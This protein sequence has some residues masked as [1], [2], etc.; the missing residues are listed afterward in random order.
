MAATIY[1]RVTEE[2]MKRLAAGVI[3]WQKPWNP[4]HGQPKNLHTGRPY[5]GMNVWLLGGHDYP[6]SYWITYKQAQERGGN[7]RRGE[8]GR[9]VVF[10]QFDR[11]S[12]EGDGTRTDRRPAPILRYYTVF[13]TAQCDGLEV[14]A[15]QPFTPIGTAAGIAAGMPNPPTLR[16]GGGRACYAPGPDLVQMPEP[17]S[18][19]R[20]ARY[21]G[22]LF[23]ELAHATGHDS[24]LKRPGIQNIQPFGTPDYSREELVAE[25]AAAYL[26]AAAG[27]ENETLDN[28][29]AYLKGWTDALGSDP[30]LI[31]VAAGQ[32]QK[33][34]DYILDTKPADDAG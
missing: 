21:Y 29:A 18:F 11:E 25:M 9:L 6:A 14:P 24:R 20:P 5:R 1:E 27:I 2:I 4:A 10:W 3:P 15:A 31:V 22:T 23:H 13:N 17:E 30:R 32:A 34:A 16:H 8:R 28:S 7:V 12:K 33:A 19:T 26:C